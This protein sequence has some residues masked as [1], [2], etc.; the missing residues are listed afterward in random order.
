MAEQ[1]REGILQANETQD[2]KRNLSLCG[3]TALKA[4]TTEYE[5][6]LAAIAKVYPPP[7]GS[8]R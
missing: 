3:I 7:S 4:A 2:G 8:T 6:A 5:E 1:F